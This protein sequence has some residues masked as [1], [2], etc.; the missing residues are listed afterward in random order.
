MEYPTITV[1]LRASRSI[2]TRAG[3]DPATNA[4]GKTI[5]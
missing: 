2:Y 1:M 4:L 3:M 5:H